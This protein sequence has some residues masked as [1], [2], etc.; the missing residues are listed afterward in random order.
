MAI[1]DGK[2]FSPYGCM[3][4]DDDDELVHL[5]PGNRIEMDTNCPIYRVAGRYF[6]DV[7]K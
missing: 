4:R 6:P 7:P 3:S 5:A 2:L 1:R